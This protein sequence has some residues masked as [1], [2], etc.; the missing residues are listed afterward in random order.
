M[1]LSA[2]PEARW[3]RA[4]RSLDGVSVGDAF[5]ERF[6]SGDA[7]E[8]ILV[9][10]TA[11]GPWRFTDDTQMALSVAA[12]LRRFGRIDQDAL[13]TDFSVHYDEDRGYGDGMNRLVPMIFL[14]GA[15]RRMAPRLFHGEGSLGNGAAMRVAPVGA[16]FADSLHSASEN[17]ALSAEVT[18]A[19]PE[20]IA[21]AVAVAVAAAYAARLGGAVPTAREFLEHVLPW[22]PPGEV[23]SGIKRAQSLPLGTAAKEAAHVLGSGYN[24]AAPDTVP[25]ALW[26][27][28]HHLGDYEEA[29]WLTVAG[30]GDC[31]TNCAIAGGV[32]ALSAG[33]S[34][35]WRA[36]REP[37]PEWAFAD[38]A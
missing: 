4:V 37:L 3:A 10:Q 38:A 22:V 23:A 2:S 5:G 7:D 33:V 25:F 15:W 26:C 30:R 17:A 24:A 32:A 14:P 12:V 13:A 1:I 11:P 8:R 28:A 29:L 31:D 6:A 35:A 19:H 21:G 16:Y 20:G 9:R 34:E 18:H 36:A 27:A